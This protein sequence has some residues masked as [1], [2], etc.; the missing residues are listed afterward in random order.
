LTKQDTPSDSYFPSSQSHLD[1]STNNNSQ[2]L[3]EEDPTIWLPPLKASSQSSV[4]QIKGFS[5]ATK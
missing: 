2:Q 5:G 1:S 3:N 4:A